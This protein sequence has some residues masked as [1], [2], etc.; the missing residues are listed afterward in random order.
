MRVAGWLIFVAGLIIM[1][2]LSL[3][4]AEVSILGTT[5][6]CGI[7]VTRIGSHSSSDDSLTASLQQECIDRSGERV[8]A[9]L[10][11]GG[12]AVVAGLLMVRASTARGG[13]VVAG[14]WWWDGRQWVDASRTPPP[15]YGAPPVYGAPP[16]TPPP[17]PPP[18]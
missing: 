18:S 16:S 12:I 7:P 4:P 3:M 5:G 6:S 11:I 14:A 1:A 2:V 15:A 10:V 13:D 9:G 8:L 17:T